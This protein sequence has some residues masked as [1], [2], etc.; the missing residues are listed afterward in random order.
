MVGLFKLISYIFVF[1]FLFIFTMFLV[2]L[3]CLLC[4]EMSLNLILRKHVQPLSEIHLIFICIHGTAFFW[5]PCWPYDLLE[6]FIRICSLRPFLSNPTFIAFSLL[7][8]DFHKLIW[9]SLR[10][11]SIACGQ[12]LSVFLFI[13]TSLHY[14]GQKNKQQRQ[15]N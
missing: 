4:S 11:Q 1:F 9:A 8:N 14:F 7:I 5:P 10:Y 15:G 2:F 12:I 3:R 6:I 13:T